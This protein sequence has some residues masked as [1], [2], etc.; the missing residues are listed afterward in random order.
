L[1]IIDTTTGAATQVATLSRQV[2]GDISELDGTFYVAG[3]GSNDVGLG[4][5]DPATGVVTEIS[6]SSPGTD[7]AANPSLSLFY[8]E[9]STEKG[10]YTITPSGSATFIGD[11]SNLHSID[12]AYDAVHGVLYSMGLS[13][14]LE[15]F[16]VTTGSGTI[17][18]TPFPARQ[19]KTIA[20]DSNNN[21]LYALVQLSSDPNQGDY[22]YSLDATTGAPT[23]VGPTGV[24]SVNFTGFADLAAPE[25]AS[26]ALIGIGLAG[27]WLVRR[28]A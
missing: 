24:S 9:G 17:L 15:T 1:W 26:A 3:F 12:L 19:A 10:L 20:Y 14:D 7:L 8:D 23:L 16:D 25:P 28:R 13:D 11:G 22:L 5:V 4:T 21:T 2:G 6:S 18:G 27:L